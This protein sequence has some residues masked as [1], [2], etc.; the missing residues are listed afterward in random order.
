MSYDGGDFQRIAQELNSAETLREYAEANLERRGRDT[1]VCPICGSGTGP[2]HSARR[3][4][5][6]THEHGAARRIE[7]AKLKAWQNEGATSPEMAAYVA[8]RHLGGY[9]CTF[10]YDEERGRLVIPF[11]GCDW[12]H[13]DRDMTGK[14]PHKY[15]KP[16]SSEV[17]PQ[18]LFN[19]EALKE[20][21]LF[22]VEGALDA[23][24]VMSLGRPAIALC[25]TGYRQLLEAMRAEGYQGGVVLMLDNDEAG[26]DAQARLADELAAANIPAYAFDYSPFEGKDADELVGTDAERL[27]EALGAAWT[28]AVEGATFADRYPN[29]TLHD[30]AEV[31]AG[32][33]LQSDAETP[34]PTCYEHLDGI[35]GGGLQRGLYVFGATSSFGKTTFSVQIG[36]AIAAQGYPVLFCTIEQSAQEITAK[37]LSRLTHDERRSTFGGKTS[38]EIVSTHGRKDW[39]AG[40]YV[41]LQAAITAY[42][43]DVAPR[44]R[45]LE[46]R[47]RPS[48]ADVR[49]AAEAMRAEFGAAPVVIIDYLQLLAARDE[50]M[51]DKQAVDDNVT[52]LRQFARDLKTPVWCVATLN[53]ESYSGPIEFESFKE[54]GAVEYG[55]DVL[56]GLQPQGI[57]EAVAEA[58]NS[59]D[60]RLKGNAYVDKAKRANPRAV[61]VTV[62]KN[63]N[64]E[65]TGNAKG[66]PFSYYPRTNLFIETGDF[67]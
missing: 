14:H 43:N 8:A 57:A 24:A 11:P 61:E 48:V 45:I 35:L 64:G 49:A 4:A 20:P 27:A 40:D 51:T 16:R 5:P 56:L 38:Q 10:G 23:Y 19:A 18:P 21:A 15:E 9:P 3:Q 42:T 30:P 37:S 31:A 65:T 44:L 6:T 36:D 50:H 39:A 28:R 22:V 12:Y 55:A 67:R 41:T 26:R 63:R 34:I 46:G 59:T 17:G 32:I 58:K 25:G 1:Y 66:I 7:A 13:I 53:R 29:M 52:A 33:Y 60:K 2:N 62:L 47:K 54:S